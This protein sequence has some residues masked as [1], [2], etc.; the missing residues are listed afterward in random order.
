MNK[1]ILIRAVTI[2]FLLMG[3]SAKLSPDEPKEFTTEF[4]EN[5]P[6]KQYCVLDLNCSKEQNSYQDCR[7][8]YYYDSFNDRFIYDSDTG[9]G[10]LCNFLSGEYLTISEKGMWCNRYGECDNLSWSQV[11]PIDE[12]RRR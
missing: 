10:Q 11:V 4:I 6:P 3:C 2:T 7:Y 12:V 8:D 5:L 1:L 9:F